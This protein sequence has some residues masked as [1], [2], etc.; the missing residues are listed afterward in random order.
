MDLDLFWK[1]LAVFNFLFLLLWVIFYTYQPS[2]M[3]DSDFIRPGANVRG[4]TDDNTKGYSDKYLSDPGRSL[5]FLSSFLTS[6]IV[7]ILGVIYVKYLV[8]RKSIECTKGAKNLKDCKI[9]NV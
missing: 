7:V 9:I 6:L 4:S 5:I 8:T 3:K 1:S 2:F